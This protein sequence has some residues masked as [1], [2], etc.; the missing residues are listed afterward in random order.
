MLLAAGRVHSVGSAIRS[1]LGVKP[2]A[3]TEEWHTALV[4]AY[5]PVLAKMQPAAD[6]ARTVVLA[7]H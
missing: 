3:L 1:V 6:L 7:G 4:D 2:S 5:K